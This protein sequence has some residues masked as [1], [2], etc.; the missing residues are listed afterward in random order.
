MSEDDERLVTRAWLRR[1]WACATNTIRE[2]E[3]S[4]SLTPIRLVNRIQYR[5]SQIKELEEEGTFRESSRRDTEHLPHWRGQ[6]NARV[7]ASSF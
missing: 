1:R 5:L 2:M 3:R 4:G 6:R 7:A